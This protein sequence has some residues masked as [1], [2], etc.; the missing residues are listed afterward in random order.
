V[1]DPNP[2]AIPVP[3]RTTTGGQRDDDGDGFGNACDPD[4]DNDGLTQSSAYSELQASNGRPVESNTCGASRTLPCDRFDFDGRGP[5]INACLLGCLDSS[6][7]FRLIFAPGTQTSLATPR[8]GPKCPDCGV[9]LD[10]LPCQGDACDRDG[11]GVQGADDNCP[12]GAN[13]SQE[14]ADA[15]GVGDACDNCS[16]IANPRQPPSFLLASPWAVLTGGQR[17]DDADGFGNACDAQFEPGSTALV[18][19][20]D[21]EKLRAAGGKPRGADSCGAEARSP[22]ATFDLSESGDAISGPDLGRFRELYLRF[23]GPKCPT[24]PL[25]CSAGTAASCAPA[26]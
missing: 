26:P 13:P 2:E 18:T 3:G 8:L 11:D 4:Y 15:D 22:C 12:D 10:R 16:R 17:D 9:V 5:E 19:S 7:F 1:Y 24:C 21:L 20:R 25:A 14:D 6:A 23:P